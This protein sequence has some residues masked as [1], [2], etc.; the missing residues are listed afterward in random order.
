MV[1]DWALSVAVTSPVA[2]GNRSVS[3]AGVPPGS[4]VSR[5]GAGFEAGFGLADLPAAEV[6]AIKGWQQPGQMSINR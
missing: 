5:S 2:V 6:L 1:G 4:V 3:V